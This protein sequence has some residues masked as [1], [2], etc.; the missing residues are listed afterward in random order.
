[1]RSRTSSRARFGKVMRSLE[2]CSKV[3]MAVQSARSFR[4]NT[5]FV[6]RP[7]FSERY[8]TNAKVLGLSV[9]FSRGMKISPMELCLDSN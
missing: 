9:D 2:L 1:M 3:Q 7:S 6:H 4:C 8:L 5:L